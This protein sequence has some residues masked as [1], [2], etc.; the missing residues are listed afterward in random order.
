M[1]GADGWG[2]ETTDGRAVPR[3]RGGWM[4]RR[5]HGW[6]SHPADEGADG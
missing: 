6:Q 5:D 3:M 4:G 1:G 2:E